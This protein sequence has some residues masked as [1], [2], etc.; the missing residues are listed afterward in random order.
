[1]DSSGNGEARLETDFE[2]I[3]WVA[4]RRR[5]ATHAARGL[6]NAQCFPANAD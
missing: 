3:G 1:M 5:S 2:I 4:Q 6:E